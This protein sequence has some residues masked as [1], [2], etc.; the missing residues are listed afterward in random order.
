MAL[1]AH[2]ITTI[3]YRV[4][5]K[6]DKLHLVAIGESWALDKTTSDELKKEYNIPKNGTI[7][8]SVYEKMRKNL[9]QELSHVE[10]FTH[11]YADVKKLHG[12][13]SSNFKMKFSKGIF[14]MAFT[15]HLPK[16]IDLKE[17]NIRMQIKDDEQSFITKPLKN[18]INIIGK[19]NRCKYS[20]KDKLAPS[21][22]QDIYMYAPLTL[23][24]INLTCKE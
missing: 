7:K 5:F 13:K 1:F 23:K 14:L 10:Y 22:E 6:I 12:L 9:T 4:Y 21:M 3:N 18:P 11:V 15:I 20:I 19:N 17:K 8:D 16:P 24:E 2:P